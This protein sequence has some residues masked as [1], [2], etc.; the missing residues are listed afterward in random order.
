MRQRFSVSPEELAA[1]LR[2]E[3]LAQALDWLAC[4]RG[5]ADFLDRVTGEPSRKIVSLHEDAI[6][7]VSH[8]FGDGIDRP[9]EY[10]GAFD[11]FIRNQ[12]D[13]VPAL[14]VVTQRPRELTRQQLQEIRRLL[15]A[16]SYSE[17]ALRAAWREATNQDV[18]AS[19][20]GH[21]RRAALGD[22]L[23]PYP[24]RVDRAL[25]KILGSRVWTQ[26]QR[27]WLERI[28][29]QIK[30]EVVVDRSSFDEGAFKADGGFRKLNK[31][32]AGR[33]PEI[34]AELQDEI[35]RQAV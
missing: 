4:N 29:Q 18:A 5:V 20:I 31:T 32:F 13:K 24:E 25:R 2:R 21:I 30:S 14:L 8:G 28:A 34:L 6:R 12:L 35:W 23:V 7:E 33:L 17:V 11:S 15:D 27:K 3:P 26:P 16:A 22:A 1:R 9:E 10:L 19:I